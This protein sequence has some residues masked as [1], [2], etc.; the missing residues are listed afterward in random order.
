[1]AAGTYQLRFAQ[2]V[3]QFYQSFGVDN[4]S[5]NAVPEP[6]SMVLFGMSVFALGLVWRRRRGSPIG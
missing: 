3:T 2:A 6:A 5:I 4:V 1:L